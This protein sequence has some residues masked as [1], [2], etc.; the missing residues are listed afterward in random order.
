[1]TMASMNS[2]RIALKAAM[3]AG[4]ALAGGQVAAQKLAAPSIEGVWLTDD[5]SGAVRISA[6]GSKLC[7]YIAQVL[8][9]RPGIPGSDINN[10]D[11][12]LRKRALVGLLTL[13]GF[14]RHGD[15]WAGGRAYDP[16]S[17]K[18][19]RSTL[20][21]EPDGSLKV[22]GCVFVICESRRWTRKR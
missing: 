5:H 17:G 21:L 16:K 6:C 3:A 14:S 10:P 1:M 20:E 11:P 8:D 4:L 12:A 19:Y 18:S 13:W 2:A 9:K 15:E 7:G 22:T